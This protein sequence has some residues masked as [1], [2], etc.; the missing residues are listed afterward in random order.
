MLAALLLLGLN[1]EIVLHIKWEGVLTL[2][3]LIVLALAIG[4]LLGGPAED[5]RTALAIAC[6]TRHIG[7][8]IM[9]ATSLPGPRTIV[10]LAVYITTSAVIS[11]PYLRWRRVVGESA[12]PRPMI[13]FQR[14]AVTCCPGSIARRSL[15]VP[16]A[17]HIGIR[18]SSGA[19][20]AVL[21]FP[22]RAVG[23]RGRAHAAGVEAPTPR[24]G[25]ATWRLAH[26]TF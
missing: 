12:N 2:A 14:G 7:V 3:A 21:P 9:V 24:T 16:V 22:A 20:G 8:A 6:A 23:E 17:R 18:S 15:Y 4:H 5:D 13:S 25:R 1:W 11:L 19:D 26:P 10:I